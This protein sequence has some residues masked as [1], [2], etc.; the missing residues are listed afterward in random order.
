M[1]CYNSTV[2][3]APVDKVWALFQ[4]FHDLSWADGV[5]T[6]VE[7]VGDAAGG[8]IG[9][10]RILN[11]AFHETMRML[12]HENRTME[13]SIDDGPPAVSKENVQGY[14]GRV[15]VSPVTDSG[16]TFVEWSSRWASGGEGTADFCNPIYRALLDALKNH[17][18]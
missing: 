15:K 11:D 3:T 13:Y 18:S 6:K 7:I 14:I 8:E 17:F 4:N 12:D 9:A 10:K 1:G 16:A 2:V 5:V